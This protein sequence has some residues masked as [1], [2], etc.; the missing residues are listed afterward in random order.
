[1]ILSIP[2]S[3]S[4]NINDY[5]KKNDIKSV[6]MFLKNLPKEYLLNYTLAINS[7]SNQKSDKFNPRVIMFSFEDEKVLTFNG[8]GYNEDDRVEILDLSKDNPE[9]SFVEFS[10]KKVFVSKKNPQSCLECHGKSPRPIFESYPVW[11]RFYGKNFDHILDKDYKVFKD[12][13]KSKKRYNILA[14]DNLWRSDQKRIFNLKN[15]PNLK[16]GVFLSTLM[17]KKYAKK[18]MNSKHYKKFKHQYFYSIYCRDKTSFRSKIIL[19]FN[20]LIRS[21]IKDSEF[22]NSTMLSNERFGLNK[23][24]LLTKE[25]NK[26]PIIFNFVNLKNID[27][28]SHYVQPLVYSN[29]YES[30][31]EIIF[32]HILYEDQDIQSFYKEFL[33]DYDFKSQKQHKFK[34]II[35]DSFLQLLKKKLNRNIIDPQKKNN[36]CKYSKNKIKLDAF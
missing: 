22:K 31:I 11:D 29:G 27:I 9:F 26:H 28:S 21:N 35:S 36:F 12:S 16:Y 15:Q 8:E 2:K 19:E 5:I 14:H 20:T 1:M 17:A 25:N 10:K 34:T 32:S 24:A 30:L 23:I 33:K 7:Q 4:L 6:E 3:F 18:I 13:M